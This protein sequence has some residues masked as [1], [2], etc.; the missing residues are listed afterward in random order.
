[1]LINPSFYTT[2]FNMNKRLTLSMLFLIILNDAG[3]AVAQLLM[4]GGLNT[5]AIN[6]ITLSNLAEF[7]SKG[8]SSPLIWLGLIVYTVNFF[9][10]IVVLSRIDLSVAMPVCSF[11]YIFVPILSIIFLGEAVHPLRWIGIFTIILGIYFVS[12]STEMKTIPL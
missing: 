11:S 3:E 5:I 9:I 10:W 12:K 1:M 6:S 8:A 4:K 7:C 2:I